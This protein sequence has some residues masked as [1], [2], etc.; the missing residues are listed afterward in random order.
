MVN[1]L[2][3]INDEL[4]KIDAEGDK[5][6][7]DMSTEMLSDGEVQEL[8]NQIRDIYQ[9]LSLHHSIELIDRFNKMCLSIVAQS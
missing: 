8:V 1:T 4:T 2:E 3:M 7:I 9:Y 5:D 6:T